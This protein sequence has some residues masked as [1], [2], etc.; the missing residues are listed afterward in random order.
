MEKK[1][2]RSRKDRIIW[3]V[4]GG[5]ADYFGI[6]PVVVR[7]VAVLLALASGAGI[8]AYI[9]LTIIIPLES[10]PA[11]EPREV[12]RENV[13]EMKQTAT[14]VGEQIRTTFAKPEGESKDMSRNRNTN[15]F[16]ALILITIGVL[17]LL[18]NLN[19]FWWL[20][21]RYLWP[22]VLIVIGLVII[23][24]RRR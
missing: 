13:E 6:D 7:V 22:L 1:L 16:I 23:L 9:I 8:I 20:Q 18:G 19:F 21:W 24:G 2:Y 10:S 14:Q 3:G 15:Y 4:C 11:K 12:V 5:I 17:F